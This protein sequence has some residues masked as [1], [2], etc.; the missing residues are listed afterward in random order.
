M[1]PDPLRLRQYVL[2]W[3]I[4]D[5]AQN[6][7]V[8]GPLSPDVRLLKQEGVLQSS[9]P[10]MRYS[11]EMASILLYSLIA[12]QE[13]NNNAGSVLWSLALPNLELD[14]PADAVTRTRAVEVELFQA[15]PVP[16]AD[17]P[18]DQVL[19]FRMRRWDELVAYRAVIGQLYQSVLSSPDRPHATELAVAEVQRRALDLNTVMRESRL[20]RLWSSVT[21][22]LTLGDF[23]TGG[24]T[25]FAAT[26]VGLPAI[27]GLAAP[28]ASKVKLKDIAEAVRPKNI[29][30]DLKDYA[31]VYHAANTFPPGAERSEAP[32]LL[33]SST[34]LLNPFYL[35]RAI[36]EA[37]GRK[38]GE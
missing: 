9:Y 12:V 14:L 18:M 28:L 1:E 20:R 2:Y 23:V 27:A 34:A 38:N 24:V 21:V 7:M 30:S 35:R 13:E 22:D 36:N 8:G 29:P 16:T 26:T 11:G 4:L 6:E 5:L 17:T 37:L 3:D 32:R 25:A 19:E 15:I 31:Y 33:R 10:S